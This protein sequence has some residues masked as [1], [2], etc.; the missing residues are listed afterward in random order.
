MDDLR[1]EQQLTNFDRHTK[2]EFLYTGVHFEMDTGRAEP[3][4]MK[5]SSFR[6]IDRD[7]GSVVQRSTMSGY[8]QKG[9]FYRAILKGISQDID[10]NGFAVQPLRKAF[11]TR[12][13]MSNLPPLLIPAEIKEFIMVRISEIDNVSHYFV[14]LENSGSLIADMTAYISN[15]EAK[16]MLTPMR[17]AEA[18][19]IVLA[20]L[21]RDRHLHRASIVAKV[22]VLQ[23]L[24]FFLDIGSLKQVPISD[25]YMLEDEDLLAVPPQAIYVCLESVHE[26]VLY[27]SQFTAMIA[28]RSLGM[29][30]LS[31]DS[32]NEAFTVKMFMISEGKEIDV[33]DILCGRCRHPPS[34][35]SRSGG[36][37]RHRS[38]GFERGRNISESSF[39]SSRGEI[40]FGRESFSSSRNRGSYIRQG[41]AGNCYGGKERADERNFGRGVQSGHQAIVNEGREGDAE[42]GRANENRWERWS[43]RSGV[44]RGSS[45]GFGSRECYNCHRIGHLSRDCPEPRREGQEGWNRSNEEC[46]NC[47]RMGHRSRDCPEP[48]TG[49][50]DDGSRFGWKRSEDSG[51][52][53]SSG[54][55]FSSSG[56]SATRKKD[57]R[58]FGSS[59]S[60]RGDT[61]ADQ[62][63]FGNESHD[64]DGKKRVDESG[65]DGSG[66]FRDSRERRKSTEYDFGFSPEKEIKRDELGGSFG[67]GF[68]SKG[69]G[70]GSSKT[71]A[72]GFQSSGTPDAAAVDY[73]K[74]QQAEWSGID[75]V[76]NDSV[77]TP[78]EHSR[79][80]RPVKETSEMVEPEKRAT[81]V[82]SQTLDGNCLGR[83]FL[84]EV[85]ETD[86]NATTATGLDISRVIAQN[87]EGRGKK[88]G[89]DQMKKRVDESGS[90]GS[91]GFRDSRE[92]RKSTE[93]DFGFSPEKEIKRDELGGSFGGGF[94]SKGVGFG[95]S[96]TAALGFQS[97]G[98]PD[99]AAV[100]YMKQQQAEWSGIDEVTN[101]SVKT[102]EEH[103][104]DMRPVKETSEMVEPEKRACPVDSQTLDGNCLGRAFLAEVNETDR[105]PVAEKS[106][107]KRDVPMIRHGVVQQIG[108]P[109]LGT[110]AMGETVKGMRSDGLMDASPDSFFVQLFRDQE[111]IE[112]LALNEMPSGCA[113]LDSPQVPMVCM[114]P[115]CETF[116]RAEILTVDKRE[117]CEVLFVDYG[118]KEVVS[119]EDI[120]LIDS[121]LSDVIRN[122]PRVA[123][124]CRLA[125]V[126]GVVFLGGGG[127]VFQLRCEVLFVD[128]GNKE[129]VSREDIYLIDSALSDVIRNSPRVAFECRLADVM[130]LRVEESFS[131]EARKEFSELTQGKLNICFV[132]KSSKGV[133]E[134]TV[135][136]DD[137]RSV[138]DVLCERGYALPLNWRKK[139][140]PAFEECKVMR[141]DD[142]DNVQS[143]FTVQLLADFGDVEALSTAYAPCTTNVE[144]PRIG[145]MAI[146]NFE[147]FPYRAEIV[148]IDVQSPC[149]D[150]GEPD[151]QV[152]RLRYVDFGNE[153]T[154]TI[155]EIFAVDRDE[156]PEM[157]LALPRLGIQCRL[158]EIEPCGIGKDDETGS[159]STEALQLLNAVIPP[160]EEITVIFGHPDEETVYPV[161]VMTVVKELAEDAANKIDGETGE[162]G[163]KREFAENERQMDLSTLLL[164][165]GLA[166]LAFQPRD[167]ATADLLT[168]GIRQMDVRIVGC[169]GAT[170]F[171]RPVSFDT[172][173]DTLKKVLTE[174]VVT[175]A[176]FGAMT[177]LIR[178]NGEY[179]RAKVL[180][181]DVSAIEPQAAYGKEGQEP[182]D[183][184][185]GSF[186]T[187][188]KVCK[189]MKS[190]VR[191]YI[192]VDEGEV[193][194]GSAGLDELGQMQAV[195]CSEGKSEFI[196][197][198]CHKLAVPLR[199]SNIRIV[200]TINEQIRTRISRGIALAR[201]RT[202]LKGGELLVDDVT[203]ADGS[204]LV[205]FLMDCRIAKK[206]EVEDTEVMS[207]NSA[208][209]D[210]N[211]IRNDISSYE[212]NL[213]DLVM[214][215]LTHLLSSLLLLSAGRVR[216]PFPPSD[217]G[218][219]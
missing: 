26:S 98:T 127:G 162:V 68:G 28:D 157:V 184:E 129:V 145:G 209:V 213:L 93:Y 132:Q 96:K 48:K 173:Y 8:V 212:G 53:F 56:F 103:S 85:N 109:C 169:D 67:G 47:H 65:S 71:A 190:T 11:A 218:H 117:G 30:L 201:I 101:D 59:G 75:E 29:Q 142:M 104:R 174:V 105:V 70:F 20:R 111:L 134:V 155:N 62:K 64:F 25:I 7:G 207:G 69:V 122:S 130:P 37:E 171:V 166:M 90:D 12:I 167:Y 45:T 205:S 144:S 63:R 33:E 19:T 151:K 21:A 36:D 153:C 208:A 148:G 191:K 170:L 99:A 135:V 102:P 115:F 97:S 119:R 46:F 49:Q 22:S 211:L 158:A 118:N 125:D 183:G 120:Y 150:R 113:M 43:Q 202:Q 40:G 61:D 66:G 185:S 163:C 196:V 182:K 10:D 6:R 139:L 50:R 124:E 187:A 17:N 146:T 89:T 79:D 203:M 181:E 198:T 5:R 131:A 121:A 180:T 84:A 9:F 147:D 194:E 42:R 176:E 193:L 34:P 72:L 128:Y 200:S 38:G 168:L 149:D 216:I 110:I 76:T 197:R 4:A 60:S 15:M 2:Q 192:L 179:K 1:N 86:R 58:G 206:V 74:Q 35:A 123:F 160:G 217:P 199:F 172:L 177:G 54:D 73:M 24:V 88:D 91:G 214:A 156:Q 87:Q 189:H 82:D 94:G 81:P 210:S 44:G 159:W 143:V 164:E 152:C 52:R 51:G 116:Y 165:K 133:Y 41:G 31:I 55:R 138:S 57:G 83:A 18:G 215:V 178:R 204:S 77:K 106:S 80:M 175:P 32:N 112:Q 39:G 186:S 140:V 108:S 154:K 95:S 92:R 27:R 195:N 100:D 23:A 141:S 16:R 107:L 14:Q 126:M 219:L 78:E 114:A 3:A 137:G 161:K 13:Q 136:L 188:N